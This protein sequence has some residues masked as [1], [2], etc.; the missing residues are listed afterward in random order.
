MS[1][2]RTAIVAGATGLTGGH[3]LSKLLADKRYVRV[4]TLVRKTSFPT[5]RKLSEIV[6]DFDALPALSV[7]DDAYCCL[8]TTI[9][10]AGSQAALRKVDFE[11]VINFARVAKVARVKRFLVIS[12]LGASARSR[13]FYNRVKGEMENALRELGFDALHIFHPSLILGERKEQ[14]PAERFGIAALGTM[15]KLL[16]GPMKKYRAIESATIARAM[17]GAATS[18]ESGTHIY[19]SDM[20]QTMATG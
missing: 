5:H 1:A 2:S 3:L 14:R 7:S 17:I 10:K 16:L 13:I 11:F 4:T 8:G 6:V 9:K 15:S 19:P 12:S 20:I 18:N